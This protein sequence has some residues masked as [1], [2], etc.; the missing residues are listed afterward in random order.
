M[1]SEQF[2]TAWEGIEQSWQSGQLAH[3]YLL[4]GS[5]SGNALS[6][7]EKLLKLIFEGDP[8][9]ATR[10]H[11]DITWIE[12]QSKSRQ[13]TI[14]EVRELIRKFSQTSFEGG[15]KTGVVLC[16]ER[17]NIAASNAF[18]KT[19]EEPP[20]QSLLILITNEPQALLP[21]IT[22]R[23]QRI[24]LSGGKTEEAGCD[25]LEIL[26][27]LPAGNV[28]ESGLL[29]A[30]F[31][32]LLKTLA[33]E[34]TAE[35][36]KRLPEDLEGKAR[37]ALLDARTGAR[38]VEA[39]TTILRTMQ[40][41]HRDLLFLALGQNDPLHFP[42]ER[43]VLERQAEGLSRGEA[44]ARIEAVEKLAMRFSRNLPAG[45]VFSEFFAN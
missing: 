12:P 41:W 28:L 42:D 4:V 43:E 35:E 26:R 8:R 23:C 24:I 20:A 40:A 30:K 39:R 2:S 3:A 37:K 19:L 22:S 32:A 45:L 34:F 33:E 29:S 21:T 6:F 36:E 10:N 9:I 18:L 16:A 17:M 11:S 15:W 13:I 14:D 7:A 31:T 1:G 25:L 27:A 5:P 44:L 38:V